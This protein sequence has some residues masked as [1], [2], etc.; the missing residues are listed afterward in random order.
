MTN[1]LSPHPTTEHIGSNEPYLEGTIMAKVP[2]NNGKE[3]TPSDDKKMDKLI[4]QNTPTPLMAYELGRS[5]NAVRSHASE[6]GKSLKP[7]N[8]SPDMRRRNK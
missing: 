5:E 6:E 7:T 4:K 1:R 2:P 8:Q 3:W